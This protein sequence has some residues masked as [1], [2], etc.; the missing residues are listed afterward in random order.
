MIRVAP[1][2]L[3]AD[4]AALGAAIDRV[5]PEAD[6]LHVDVMDGHFVPNLTIGPPVVKAIRRHTDLYLDCHLMM[7]NPGDYLEAFR[8]AGADSCSVH[9]EVGD[10]AGLIGTMRD[11]GLGVGLAVNPET[12]FDATRPW[13]DRIDLLLVMTVHPGFGGQSFMG[14]VVPKIATAA[15]A[16]SEQGLDVVLE[17]DGGI[18]PATA[19]TV[20]GAGARMLVAGSA[21]FGASDPLEAAAAIRRAAAGALP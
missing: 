2:I 19:P 21:I 6:W 20:A 10:T 4:F 9:V 15:Q 17:V 14:E 18:D 11:L 5:A 12:P 16:I 8:A 7:T 3:S 13:L 1:S